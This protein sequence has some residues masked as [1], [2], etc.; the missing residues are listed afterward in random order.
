M[1]ITQKDIFDFLDARDPD[2]KMTLR[3][4]RSLL[5]GGSLETI[6]RAVR[7]YRKVKQERQIAEM[8]EVYSQVFQKFAREV[9]ELTIEQ[10]KQE[11]AKAEAAAEENVTKLEAT[12][13][14]LDERLAVCHGEN[15]ELKARIVALTEDAAKKKALLD[16]AEER[17][18]E[19]AGER[20]AARAEVES[21]KKAL[22][23]AKIA[24]A[25]AEAA[26][27][28]YKRALGD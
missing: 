11:V 25:T 5:G 3:E 17:A 8:P 7:A 22:N 15:D 18:L 28:A 4:M 20:D 14:D 13:K 19:F 16:V 1:A 27:T 2:T 6:S 12:V 9:W 10:A 26:L 24:Q 23:D 21:L